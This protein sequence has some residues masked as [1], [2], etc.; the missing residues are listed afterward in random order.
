M[1]QKIQMTEY[2]V[3]NSALPQAFDGFRILQ[4]SDFHNVDM[5]LQNQGLIE[6]IRAEGPDMIAITGDMLDAR[7]PDVALCLSMLRAM[8]EIA[9]CYF[10]P[11]NHEAK[12]KSLYEEMETQMRAMPNICVLRDMMTEI[13]QHGSTLFIMGVED[14][15]FED[16]RN[17]ECDR[18]LHKKLSKVVMPDAYVVLLTHRPDPLWLYYRH[19]I[20]LALAGHAHGGQVRLPILGALY[21]PN[22]GIFPRYTGGVYEKYHTQMVVSRG[23]GSQR[24][25]PRI[26]NKAEIP[27]ITLRV[28]DTPPNIVPDEA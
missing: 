1:I 14:P 4:F 8:S 25:V 18:I 5:G 3:G 15:A 11:G 27:I 24:K 20:G 17:S 12:L 23:I 9:P 26:N 10:V 13:N 7:K 21:S 28:P 2:T 22:Q 19:N 16:S 6:A